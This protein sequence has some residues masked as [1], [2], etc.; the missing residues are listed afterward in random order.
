MTNHSYITY[1]IYQLSTST[2]GSTYSRSLK[3]SAPHIEVHVVMGEEHQEF[4]V[5]SAELS[6]GDCV[7]IFFGGKVWGFDENQH[8][9]RFLKKSLVDWLIGCGWL[10]GWLVISDD[11]IVVFVIF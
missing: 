8:F 4:L 2:T 5:A 6:A 11:L 10:F 1:R 7:A 9:R 3:K